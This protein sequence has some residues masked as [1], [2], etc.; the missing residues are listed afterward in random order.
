MCSSSVSLH[1]KRFMTWSTSDVH[2]SGC[3]GKL[4]A[5][6]S[7]LEENDKRCEW[8][9]AGREEE[10]ADAGVKDAEPRKEEV[11]VW[12]EEEDTPLGEKGDEREEKKKSDDIGASQSTSSLLRFPVNFPSFPSFTVFCFSFARKICLATKSVVTCTYEK[13]QSQV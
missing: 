1:C 5:L 4:D 11:E 6:Q 3:Q 9:H 7:N 10:N 13:I 2:E 8:L 12:E